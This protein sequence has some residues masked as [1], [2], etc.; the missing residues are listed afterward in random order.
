MWGYCL[1]TDDFCRLNKTASSSL[2]FYLD[3]F[4]HPNVFKYPFLPRGID[5]P[6][7]RRASWF[8]DVCQWMAHSS[9]ETV[10]GSPGP[11]SF[12]RAPGEER[13]KGPNREGSS[14]RSWRLED[15]SSSSAIVDTLDNWNIYRLWGKWQILLKLR[16]FNHDQKSVAFLFFQ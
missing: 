2:A 9:L 13:A 4:Y 14:A 3:L 5:N 10:W 6:S 15:T 7:L 1:H 8:T 11:S 12:R 16:I